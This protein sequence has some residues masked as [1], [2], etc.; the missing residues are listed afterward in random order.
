MVFFSKRETYAKTA[1]LEADLALEQY[2]LQKSLALSKAQQEQEVQKV[3]K[4]GLLERQIMEAKA[5]KE[6]RNQETE[7]ELTANQREAEGIRLKSKAETTGETI[8]A[9]LIKA[10]P[11]FANVQ[12]AKLLS[13]AIGKTNYLAVADI[14]NK[15]PPAVAIRQLLDSANRG[16]N[17][18]PLK[19]SIVG[20]LA[21]HGMFRE[22]PGSNAPIRR[23]TSSPTLI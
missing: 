19:H 8:I 23:T 4:S 21:A 16:N 12:V 22:Q 9:E 7:A 1:K 15:M 14:Y 2:E 3:E 17:V 5:K 11:E 10:N 20:N 18:T 13:E 6:I